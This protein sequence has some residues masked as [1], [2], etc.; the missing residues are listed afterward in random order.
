[1]RIAI[2]GGGLAGTACAYILKNAGHEPVIYEASNTLASGASGNKIGLYNPRFSTQMDKNAQYFSTA[3]FEALTLFEQAGREIDWNPCGTLY[4]INDEKRARRYPRINESWDWLDEDMRIVSAQ[5]ASTLAG[6]EIPN[7][8]LYLA[9]SG[10]ISP[11]KICAYYAKDIEV[12]LNHEI[13]SLKELEGFDTFILACGLGAKQFYPDLQI[14]PV[15]GQVTY[16]K[17]TPPMN[18]LKSVVEFGGSIA[19]EHGGAHF[20]GSTFQPWLDHSDI[21]DEDDHLNIERTIEALPCLKG[22]YKVTDHRAGVRVASKNHMPIIG[23]VDEIRGGMS[24]FSSVAHGS[25]GILSSLRGA[26]IISNALS[27][28]EG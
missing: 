27:F 4:L 15:R 1:M 16:V 23:K 13:N 8:A 2:I 7:D 22:A 21:L 3:Y 25:Y 11:A 26:Q 6:I 12:N 10:F 20:L 19:P 14:K 18:K 5:E 17:S 28:D 24:V 9:R